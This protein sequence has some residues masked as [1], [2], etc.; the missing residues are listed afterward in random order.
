MLIINPKQQLIINARSTHI[1]LKLLGQE[2]NNFPTYAPRAI[3][4]NFGRPPDR[5]K[6]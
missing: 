4:S 6:V 2:E 3:Q 5:L 1:A